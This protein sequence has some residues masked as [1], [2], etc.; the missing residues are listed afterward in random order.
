MAMKKIA[1]V[2]AL[3]TISVA[4]LASTVTASAASGTTRHAQ[5]T[6]ISAAG[7][8][9]PRPAPAAAQGAFDGMWA[10]AQSNHFVVRLIL[11]APDSAGNFTG[12]ADFAGGNGGSVTGHLSSSDVVFDI[13]LDHGHTGRYTG[14]QESADQWSGESVDLDQPSSQAHWSAHRA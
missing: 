13:R 7:Q 3:M 4:G 11:N 1:A 9:L 8:R 10:M 12:S 14:H 6:V 5:S 2:A